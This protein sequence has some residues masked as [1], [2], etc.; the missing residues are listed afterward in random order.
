MAANNSCS[1]RCKVRVENNIACLLASAAVC[2]LEKKL[3]RSSL[4]VNSPLIAHVYTNYI[5]NSFSIH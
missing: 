5:S 3:H 2:T 4:S 1:V